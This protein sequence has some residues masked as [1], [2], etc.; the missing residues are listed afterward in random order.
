MDISSA[1]NFIFGQMESQ[2][3]LTAVGI[4]FKFMLISL[5]LQ[6]SEVSERPNNYEQKYL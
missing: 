6:K 2:N 4:Y 1:Y 3:L 5:I